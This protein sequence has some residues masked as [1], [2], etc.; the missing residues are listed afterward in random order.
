MFKDVGG[1]IRRE[2]FT[3]ACTCRKTLTSFAD[4][5]SIKPLV[6]CSLEPFTVN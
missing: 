6:L 5:A 3:D 2:V 1:V 4:I